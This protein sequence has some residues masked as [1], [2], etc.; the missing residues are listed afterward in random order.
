MICFHLINTR[1]LFCSETSF[2]PIL[3][4][5]VYVQLWGITHKRFKQWKKKTSSFLWGPTQ[6]TKVYGLS[7]WK[8]RSGFA[9]SSPWKVKTQTLSGQLQDLKGWQRG[10]S[11]FSG[12]ARRDSLKR[13]CFRDKHV[14]C[15]LA[16]MVT[17]TVCAMGV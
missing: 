9:E 16:A 8:D 13:L 3:K 4:G 6:P 5:G 12:T 2:P 14:D 17:R 7:Q 10:V 15:L 1:E 11:S